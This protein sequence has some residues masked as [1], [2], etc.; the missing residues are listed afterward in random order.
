MR[1]WNSMSDTIELK[2]L[3][4]TMLSWTEIFLYSDVLICVVFY[5]IIWTCCAIHN[6]ISVL[7]NILK[8]IPPIFVTNLVVTKS[9]PCA[10]HY[11]Q[12]YCV[13]NLVA[14]IRLWLPLYF[15]WILWLLCKNPY[16]HVFF[17]AKRNNVKFEVNYRR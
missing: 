7:L 15:S 16:N 9:S 11:Y 10:N 8:C 5:F 1:K 12:I 17:T 13:T 6:S 14:I 4:M 2:I 3:S